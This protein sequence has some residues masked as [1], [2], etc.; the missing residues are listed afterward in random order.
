M[1]DT[2]VKGLDQLQKMLDT[3]PAKVEKNILRSA[4][5]AG[6][7]PVLDAAKAGAPVRSGALQ[8][9]LRISTS[10]KRG[11]VRAAVKT[12]KFY[13][14][15]VEFGTAAHEI[16]PEVRAALGFGSVVVEQVEHPGASAKPFLRPALDSQAQ[17]AV[18]AAANQIKRRL[19]KAGLNA[20][21][22]EVEPDEG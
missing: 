16:V 3:L 6:A 10:A 22:V 9:S 20:A 21:S 1:A 15:F 2:K 19:T 14:R 4:L 18:V 11:Q 13:A 5:R 8:K 17:A 7:K 12:D